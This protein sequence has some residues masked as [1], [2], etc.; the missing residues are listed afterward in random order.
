MLSAPQIFID[1]GARASVSDIEGLDRVAFLT[2]TGMMELDVLLEHL[3]IIGGSYIG[4][5]FAQMYRR[6]GSRVTVIEKGPRLIAREDEE[7]SDA[8]RLILEGEGIDIRLNAECLSVKP[9]GAGVAV[10]LGCD[11]EPHGIVGSHLLIAVGRRPNTDDLG[12]ER[13]G[14]ALDE[15][16]YIVVDDRLRISVPGIWAMDDVNGRS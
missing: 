4:L 12:C 14:L 6:F 11:D 7:V 15:H 5:E 16:G 13:A 2:N 1:T 9:D 8:I 10:Q 3:V